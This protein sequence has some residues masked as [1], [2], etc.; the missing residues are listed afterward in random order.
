MTNIQYSQNNH[1]SF[2]YIWMTDIQ[3]DRNNHDSFFERP[4]KFEL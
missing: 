3:C 2:V 4:N 1:D